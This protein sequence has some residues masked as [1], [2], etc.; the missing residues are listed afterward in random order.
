MEQVSGV[1]LAQFRRWYSQAGT[2]TLAIEQDY[3]ATDIA[4]D[5]DP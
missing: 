2:P 1:D 5:P 4:T 3:D